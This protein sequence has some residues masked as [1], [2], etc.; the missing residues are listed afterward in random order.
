MTKP[1]TIEVELVVP[2]RALLRLKVDPGEAE[3]FGVAGAHRTIFD[4]PKI[5]EASLVRAVELLCPKYELLQTQE[6]PEWDALDQAI[7]KALAEQEKDDG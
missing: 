5:L 7:V 3:T 4:A 2:V 1:V 6:A